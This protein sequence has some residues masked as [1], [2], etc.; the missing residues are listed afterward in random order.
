MTFLEMLVFPLFSVNTLASSIFFSNFYLSCAC[1]L[2]FSFIG[3]ILLCFSM[4][5]NCDI[6]CWIIVIVS[7]PYSSISCITLSDIFNFYPAPTPPLIFEKFL[8]L[9]T[10]FWIISSCLI[11]LVCLSGESLGCFSGEERVCSRREI[12]LWSKYFFTLLKGCESGEELLILA[13]L[14]L[15]LL[16]S[17]GDS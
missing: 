6:T 5:L 16:V 8:L 1:L 14:K 12:E 10:N 13:S 11:I 2:Y 9:C 15:L 4:P 17:V 3:L 7:S